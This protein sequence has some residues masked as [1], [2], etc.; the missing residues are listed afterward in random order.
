MAEIIDIGYA[1]KNLPEGWQL[2]IEIEKGSADFCLYDPDG[3]KNCDFC[4]D[5]LTTHAML[6]Q[7]VDRAVGIEAMKCKVCQGTGGDI[8]PDPE[9]GEAGGCRHCEGSGTGEAQA[10][11]RAVQ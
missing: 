10:T 3:N 5:D 1:A 11:G 6:K 2:C 9:T 7:R 4:D 8:H